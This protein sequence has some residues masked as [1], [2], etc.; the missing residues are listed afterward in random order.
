MFNLNP[1]QP[2]VKYRIRIRPLRSTNPKPTYFV[3]RIRIRPFSKNRSGSATLLLPPEIPIL[4]ISFQSLFLMKTIFFFLVRANQGEK[5]VRRICCTGSALQSWLGR[6]Q[7]HLIYLSS[8]LTI[9]LLFR[10]CIILYLTITPRP[11]QPSVTGP[12]TLFIVYI[13]LCSLIN[14][15]SWAEFRDT[16]PVFCLARGVGA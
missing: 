9:N 10:V 1:D 7:Y 3:I 11:S 2:V 6:V 5:T 4:S 8:Y 16:K 14:T 15:G 13:L 12:H